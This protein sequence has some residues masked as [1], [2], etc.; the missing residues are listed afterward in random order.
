MTI[1]ILMVLSLAGS[2]P[3][4]PVTATAFS[5][6]RNCVK[7]SQV[8]NA[9]SLPHAYSWC[10]EKK[11]SGAITPVVLTQDPNGGQCSAADLAALARAELRRRG[12]QLPP[13]S[14]PATQPARTSPH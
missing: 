14:K 12:V 9:L 6:A 8:F 13:Q 7:Q 5:D 3:G 11:S 2:Q 4:H 10:A 1:Y